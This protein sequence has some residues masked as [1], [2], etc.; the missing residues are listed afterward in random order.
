MGLFPKKNVFVFL[1]P[2]DSYQKKKQLCRRKIFSSSLLSLRKLN[3][4]IQ[5]KRSFLFFPL[6]LLIREREKK[7]DEKKGTIVFVAEKLNFQIE[8]FQRKKA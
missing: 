8:F 5:Q 3:L 1:R 2:F 7:R 4:K 6:Y